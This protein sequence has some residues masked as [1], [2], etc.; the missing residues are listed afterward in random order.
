[1]QP[2]MRLAMPEDYEAMGFVGEM[3]TL[4]SF[5]L[6]F[7]GH[8]VALA[9]VRYTKAPGPLRA[10]VDMK[11][12]VRGYPVALHRWIRAAIAEVKKLGVRHMLAVADPEIPRAAAWLERLGFDYVG[13]STAGEVWEW[14]S[15]SRPADS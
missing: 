11:P 14:C 13:E 2:Q 5:A 9:T 12:E 6:L 10:T 8:A 4:R 7:D 1:M 3:G 15:F